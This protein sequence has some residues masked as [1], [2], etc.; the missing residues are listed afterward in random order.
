[1]SNKETLEEAAE[2]YSIIHG[3]KY[4][5]K[6]ELHFVNTFNDIEN[7]F[8][9]GAKWQQER[10]YSEEEVR[11]IAEEVRWQAIGNPL[12]FTKNF[13]KWFEKFK[14]KSL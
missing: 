13:E 8:I 5:V 6:G 7:A 3:E 2:D 12:E 11:K 1:M 4:E 14:K 10:S 9:A